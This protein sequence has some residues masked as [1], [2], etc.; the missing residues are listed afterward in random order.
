MAVITISRQSGSEGNEIAKILCEKLA[1]RLFD[2]S[3]IIQLAEKLGPES[4]KITDASDRF[5]KARALVERIL[6]PLQPGLDSQHQSH[7]AISF[8][9]GS[10]MTEAQVRDLILA[11][12][13]QGNVV[14]VGRGSQV[15]LAGMPDVLHVRIVA[16]LETR[17]KVWQEREGLSFEDASKRVHNRDKAHVDFVKHFFDTDISDPALYDMVINTAK[18]PPGVA[19]DLII[20]GLWHL[21]P[22]D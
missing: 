11:A 14:I 15:V 10:A 9:N 17:I 16:P 3:L 21:Q 13:S 2:K 22:P 20:E 12:H 5:D 18:F 6:N 7:K 19:A 4:S 8:E 1:Y